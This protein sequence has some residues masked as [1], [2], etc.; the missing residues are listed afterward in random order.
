MPKE[1]FELL[2]EAVIV[3]RL[4]PVTLPFRIRFLIVLV[5]LLSNGAVAEVA[6]RITDSKVFAAA[7]VFVI[8]RFLFVP[9]VPALSPSIVTLSAPLS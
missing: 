5:L 1:E 6:T 4:P 2:A 9:A 7:S 3:L 8:V